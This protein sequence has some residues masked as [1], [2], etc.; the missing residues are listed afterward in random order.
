MEDN[1]TE[2]ELAADLRL[3]R[4]FKMI[5]GLVIVFFACMIAYAAY[6]HFFG[7]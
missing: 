3:E 4:G 2:A 6:P 5:E 1:R 7:T